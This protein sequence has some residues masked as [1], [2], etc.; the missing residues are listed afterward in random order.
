MNAAQVMERITRGGVIEPGHDWTQVDVL[1]P[2]P[3][4]APRSW[5]CVVS[6]S[7]ATFEATVQPL[8][9]EAHAVAA[10][11]QARKEA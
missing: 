8:L 2:H 11:R 1:L 4:Y 5:V 3:Q 6:P 10:R 7:D 9:A